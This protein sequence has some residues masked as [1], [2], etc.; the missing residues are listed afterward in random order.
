MLGTFFAKLRIKKYPVTIV[1][2]IIV[3][4]FQNCSN[5]R[6]A[7][8]NKTSAPSQVA[9]TVLCKNPLAG[10]NPLPVGST[11]TYYTISSGTASECSDHQIQSAC[12]SSGQFSSELPQ[13]IETLF[14]QG[15]LFTECTVKNLDPV[16]PVP[17][18][19]VVIP[20]SVSTDCPMLTRDNNRCDISFNTPGNLSNSQLNINGAVYINAVSCDYGSLPSTLDPKFVVTSRISNVILSISQYTAGIGFAVVGQAGPADSGKNIYVCV[21]L[22]DANNQ[23]LK[24][25][26]KRWPIGAL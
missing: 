23:I 8:E 14:A 18:A 2:F 9:Q 24:T 5:V 20:D 10:Q 4:F 22:K 7:P 19:P 1:F 16:Q 17:A 26:F 21:N 11:F 13:N 25:Y 6:F 15:T 3:L 12:L